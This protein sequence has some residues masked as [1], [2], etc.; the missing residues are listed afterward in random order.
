VI[1]F[2][3]DDDAAVAGISAKKVMTMTAMPG[4]V[5]V[6]ADTHTE[7]ATVAAFAEAYKAKR[8]RAV[9]HAVAFSGRMLV[10]GWPDR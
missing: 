1:P 4:A 2:L 7:L 3:D 5:V 8:Q 10:I 9:A 6:P